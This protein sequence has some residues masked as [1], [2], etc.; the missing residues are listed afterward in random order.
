MKQSVWK[1]LMSVCTAAVLGVGLMV[2][3]VSAGAQEDGAGCGISGMESRAGFMM[4]AG[5]AARR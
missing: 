4:T 3:A 2:P 5:R 1:R